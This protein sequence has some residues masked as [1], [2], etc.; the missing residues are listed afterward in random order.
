[1]L[2]F[3]DTRI[4]IVAENLRL[5]ETCFPVLSTNPE[6]LSLIRALLTLPFKMCGPVLWGRRLAW[7][8]IHAWGACDPGFKSQRPHHRK[9]GTVFIKY[10]ELTKK[11]RYYTLTHTLHAFQVLRWSQVD[12]KLPSRNLQVYTRVFGDGFGRWTNS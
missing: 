1:M 8:R 4:P 5:P 2:L 3:L 12:A 9:P 11:H 7:T 10:G 6:D